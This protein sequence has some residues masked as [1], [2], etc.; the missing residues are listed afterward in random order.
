MTNMKKLSMSVLAL[1]LGLGVSFSS[2][3]S[4]SGC[5]Q[6]LCS[7]NITASRPALYKQCL[8]QCVD[9]AGGSCMLQ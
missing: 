2:F 6:N 1:G 8:N 4:N 9:T 7:N 5:C 3:A